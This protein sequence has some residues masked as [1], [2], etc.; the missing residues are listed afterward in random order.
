MCHRIDAQTRYCRNVLVE[1]HG[2]FMRALGY[3]CHGTDR[4]EDIYMMLDHH[5]H[6][7]RSQS[8]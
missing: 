4:S 8:L 2:V 1:A 3:V 5:L 7:K 6:A